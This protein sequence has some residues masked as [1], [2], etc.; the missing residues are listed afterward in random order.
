MDALNKLVAALG[1]LS[2]I[3][4]GVATCAASLYV[5]NTLAM[6]SWGVAQSLLAAGSAV[7]SSSGIGLVTA[8]GVLYLASKA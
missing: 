7:M 6:P 1:S 5:L 4:R 8:L 2:D 3:A